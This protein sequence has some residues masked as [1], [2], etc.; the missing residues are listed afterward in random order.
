[1]IQ[2]NELRLGNWI[3][4]VN[5]DD[6]KFTEQVIPETLK[7]MCEDEDPNFEAEERHHS[8]YE[9]ISLTPEIL[10]KCGWGG[11]DFMEISHC[12]FITQEHD[13]FYLQTEYHVLEKIHQ[14]ELPIKYLHELQNLY[15]ALTGKELEITI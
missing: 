5:H 10:D 3:Y 8:H 13:T 14:T 11:K 7:R 6:D 4:W 12:C 15:F 1:M 2:S 9:P